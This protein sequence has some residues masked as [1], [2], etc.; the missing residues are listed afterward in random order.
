MELWNNGTKIANFSGNRINT[1]L[2][3]LFGTVTVYEVDSKGAS[4]S[5]SIHYNGPC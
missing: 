2:I 4:Q 5:A 1:A 3:M